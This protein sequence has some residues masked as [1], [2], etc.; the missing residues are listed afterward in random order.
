MTA[1]RAQ[2]EPTCAVCEFLEMRRLLSAA[3]ALP[4]VAVPDA[5]GNNKWGSITISRQYPALTAVGDLNN[6]GGLHYDESLAPAGGV[7]PGSS[8]ITIK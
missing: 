7:V 3:P 5:A 2:R 4:P 6:D 8:V 1:D